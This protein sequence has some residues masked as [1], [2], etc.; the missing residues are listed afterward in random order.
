MEEI[1]ELVPIEERNG[2]Q[3]V[4]ARHLYGWL[5]VK[6]DFSDWMKAQIIRCDL[7]E[8]QDFEVFPQKVENSKG[9]RPSTE[10]ALSL[11]AAKEIS[12]MSQTEKGKQARRY[13]IEC[14]R[15]AKN[16]I[17]SLSRK[18]L[19]LMVIEA[20]EENE[21][22]A[23]VNKKQANKIEEDAPKV[24]FADALL[25]SPDSILIGELAKILRQNGYQTGEIRLFEQLRNEGYLCVSGSDYNL[26]KQEYVE[27]GYFEITKGTRS[28][29]NGVLHQTRTTKVLPKGVKYFINKYVKHE[30]TLF[31]SL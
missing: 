1:R 16:P 11:D 15:I 31:D 30:P 10:Y 5:E 22:L 17:A 25:G 24:I 29:N 21:R 4:N 19:A 28:D 14:E 6:K 27:R 20:E 2:Q 8:N 12:M 3:A 13:F 9:G 26:P 7:V 23:L 18:Q